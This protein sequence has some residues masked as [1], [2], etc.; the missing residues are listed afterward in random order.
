MGRPGCPPG[1]SQGEFPWLVVVAFEDLLAGGG[2]QSSGAVGVAAGQ[3]EGEPG[4]QRELDVW[5]GDAVVSHDAVPVPDVLCGL[6]APLGAEQSVVGAG[7][8][9]LA[10]RAV[11]VGEGGLPGLSAHAAT[12]FVLTAA[13]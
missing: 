3:H 11:V 12:P 4:L 9:L 1:N 2:R 6:S 8:G 13:V 7:Q 5:V 10:L